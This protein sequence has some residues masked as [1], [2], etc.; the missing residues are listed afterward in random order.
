MACAE[1]P[2][3]RSRMISERYG[4]KIGL[5]KLLGSQFLDRLGAYRAYRQV[6][7]NDV[8]R[9]VFVCSGNICRSAYAEG[10]ATQLGLRAVSAGLSADRSGPADRRAV[11]FAAGRSVDLSEH[12]TTPVGDL[13]LEKGDLILCMEP[14]QAFAMTE[15]A[16]SG[17]S[18]VTLLG[19]WASEPRPYLQDPYGLLD[20]YWHTCFALIDSA[21]E[22]VARRV[23]AEHAS[24][25]CRILNAEP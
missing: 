13:E 14:F 6:R 8:Q 18:Q 2:S 4:R 15:I 17:A 19:L 10:R 11:R 5:L 3:R 22:E 16:R 20:G 24:T 23:N 9:L 25:G 7:W 12:R 21:V 1:R